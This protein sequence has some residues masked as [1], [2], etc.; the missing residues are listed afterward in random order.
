MSKSNH[1]TLFWIGLIALAI[2]Y[3]THLD[4]VPVHSTEDECRRA[5]VPLEMC[6]SDNWIT[7][8]LN[9]ELYLNKPPFF[10]WIV[11]TSYKVFGEYSPFALRFPV[12][13]SILL[14]GIVIFYSVRKFTSDFVGAMTG[15]AFMTNW[16]TLTLDSNLGLLEHPLALLIY[17]GFILIYILGE[18]RQ[19]FLLFVSTYIIAAVGFLMKGLP[20]VAHHGIAL[21]MYFI[22]TKNFRRLFSWQHFAGIATFLLVLASYYIP[23]FTATDLHWKDVFGKL[24]FESSK[25]YGYEGAGNFLSVFFDFP[26]DFIKHFL[27]WTLLSVVLFQKK[28][29]SKLKEN[30]FVF[31]NALLFAANTPIYWLASLKNPHYLF[32][33]LPLLFTVLFSFFE[34]T[35][36]H[37]W[38]IKT[39]EIIIAILLIVM[40]A[41]CT[42]VPWSNWVDTIDN[43][44]L[45]SAVCG[46]LLAGFLVCYFKFSFYRIYYLAGSLIVLRLAFNWFV[47]PQRVADQMVY[48]LHA[49]MIDKLVGDQP[50]AIKATYPAG[51]YDAIT[52]PLEIMRNE[53]LPVTNAFTAGSYFLTDD[54]NLPGNES[55]VLYEFDYD[56]AD[57]HEWY[58]KKMYLVRKD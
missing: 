1:S 15:L 45:K 17:G 32:F 26:V 24:F 49:E 8:T 38:Q 6:L 50:L 12:V 21:L 57:N 52:F 31:F 41:A 16:R 37:R 2:V 43:V 34:S 5:L 44:G 53:I 23:F 46:L 58:K 25:R 18:R 56:Y 27:P 4:R 39:I 13:I 35:W 11:A 28:W 19:Y 40:T 54:E 55:E 7:P 30:K 29:F 33:L 14:T 51:Y 10:S 20:S 22:F 3:L 36:R 47:I 42:Y 9:G 48:P